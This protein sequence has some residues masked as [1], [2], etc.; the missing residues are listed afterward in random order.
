MGLFTKKRSDAGL[1]SVSEQSVK[2]LHKTST[3]STYGRPAGNSSPAATA[4][5]PE[6]AIPKAPD[7]TLNPAQYLRSIYA[8]RER[9]KIVLDLGKRN[10]LKHFDVDMTKFAETAQYV[11]MIINVSLAKCVTDVS[12]APG[13]LT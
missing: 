5:I 8:V 4:T 2:G 1:G 11:V 6:I 13:M 7:A 9:S 10:K 12:Q 3:S